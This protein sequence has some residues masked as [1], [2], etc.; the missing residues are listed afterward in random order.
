MLLCLQLA[1]PRAKQ[2]EPKFN[3]VKHFRETSYLNS[4]VHFSLLP[5]QCAVDC[6]TWKGVECKVQ[7]VKKVECR[8]GGV[9]CRV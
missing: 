6:G 7:R 8:V 1:T 9:V 5:G 4:L 3:Q 2:D